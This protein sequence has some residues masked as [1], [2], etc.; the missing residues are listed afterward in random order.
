MYL[1]I[2]KLYHVPVISV[3]YDLLIQLN[4]EHY[5]L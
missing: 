5:L 1:F 4:I 2:I 3:L